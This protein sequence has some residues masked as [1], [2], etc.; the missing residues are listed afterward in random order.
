[1]NFYATVCSL[2]IL[3][4]GLIY[5]LGFSGQTPKNTLAPLKSS[6]HSIILNL[7]I[8][9]DFK[10]YRALSLT[11]YSCKGVLN[12]LMNCSLSFRDTMQSVKYP[13]LKDQHPLLSYT[14]KTGKNF[15]VFKLKDGST[16]LEVLDTDKL[17]MVYSFTST[18]NLLR[19]SRLYKRD[20]FM[21]EVPDPSILMPLVL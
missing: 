7:N 17:K 19:F 15:K 1:M 16:H 13:N 20:V 10:L 2:L 12:N 4:A 5:N 21:E 11:N 18:Q 9:S 14:S 6:E 8:K 3:A